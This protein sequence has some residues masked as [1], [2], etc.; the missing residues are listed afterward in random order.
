MTSAAYQREWARR[1]PD[2]VKAAQRRYRTAHRTTRNE[3]ARHRAAEL[4]RLDP[5][6][7]R[8]QNAAWRAAN[9]ERHRRTQRRAHLRRLYGMTPEQ[10]EARVVE[11][12]GKCK[13]CGTD[14]PGRDVWSVDHCH[15]TKTVRGLLCNNCNRALGLFGDDIEALKAAV[16]Y[17][18]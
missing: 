10:Y 15:K 3:S 17:L 1:N 13:I 8:D 14:D 7:V 18:S 2:K 12:G 4:R 9:P 11:Q 16:E 6:K 5:A